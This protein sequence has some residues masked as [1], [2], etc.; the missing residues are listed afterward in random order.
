MHLWSSP[1]TLNRKSTYVSGTKRYLNTYHGTPMK[2]LM[3]P[4]SLGREVAIRTDN[5]K[6]TNVIA[7]NTSKSW[8][9]Y[10]GNNMNETNGYVTDL[11][12]KF[13]SLAEGFSVLAKMRTSC[14]YTALRLAQAKLIGA[15]WKHQ[16]PMCLRDTPETVEHYLL[17]CS[18]WDAARH[19]YLNDTIA[20]AKSALSQNVPDMYD[21]D[22][23]NIVALLLGGSVAGANIK[24]WTIAHGSEP[25]VEHPEARNCAAVKV[26]RF[27]QITRSPR[28]RVMCRLSLHN[29][30]GQGPGG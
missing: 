8:A 1:F 17:D 26:A 15:M 23:C 5:R 16:C 7:M 18:E 28:S 14:F 27:L 24:N 19:D 2:A 10:V 6:R 22:P 29:P 20:D 3:S 4:T 13:V 25:N 30:T 21:I 11:T 9:N 12:G